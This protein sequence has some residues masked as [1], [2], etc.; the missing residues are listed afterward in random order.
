ML[1][2]YFFKERGW[3]VSRRMCLQC[4]LKV[5]SIERRTIY[6]FMRMLKIFDFQ[7]MGEKQLRY[8]LK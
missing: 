5:E 7:I 3:I 1:N 4:S 8:H 6:D 2:H